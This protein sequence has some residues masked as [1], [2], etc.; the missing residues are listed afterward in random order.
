MLKNSRTYSHKVWICTALLLVGTVAQCGAQSKSASSKAVID[1]GERGTA[2]IVDNTDDVEATLRGFRMVTRQ[3]TGS[4]F[5]ISRQGYYITNAHVVADCPEGYPLRMWRWDGPNMARASRAVVLRKDEALDLALLKTDDLL[6]LQPLDLG[7]DTDIAPKTSVYAFG[8]P[9]GYRQ[10]PRRRPTRP[11]PVGPGVPIQPFFLQPEPEQTP[12]HVTTT[13]GRIT[14]LY[15]LR[16]VL[17]IIESSATVSHG[18]SGGP[19]LNNKGKVIGVVRAVHP[20]NGR[21]LALPVRDLK[22][23]LNRP[24][25]ALLLEPP[26]ISLSPLSFSADR[27]S[28]RRPFEVQVRRANGTSYPNNNAGLSVKVTLHLPGSESGRI[29]TKRSPKGAYVVQ[30]LPLLP[31]PGVR[32]FT[33]TARQGSHAT[34]YYRVKDQNLRVGEATI[35]LR[36][37]RRIIGGEQPSVLFAD[38][39]ER[40]ANV[41]GLDLLQLPDPPT[42]DG[43]RLDTAESISVTEI[44]PLPSAMVYRVEVMAGKRLLA[45]KSGQIALTGIPPRRPQSGIV[46]ACADE[47]PTNNTGGNGAASELSPGARQYIQNIADLFTAGAPG[48]FLI[49]TDHWTFGNPFQETLRAAGHTVT[50][51]LNPARLEGYDGV[52]VGGRTVPANQLLRYVKQGGRVY[53]AGGCHGN[54]GMFWNTFLN[55]FGL[56]MGADGRGDEWHITPEVKHTLFAGVTDLKVVGVSP[57]SKQ[58]GAWPNTRLIASPHGFHLWGVYS[59]DNDL[60]MPLSEAP[61]DTE[62]NEKAGD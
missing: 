38:G 17:K 10:P 15:G 53:V 2:L 5:C 56:T 60:L 31:Q 11:F 13:W 8:F 16:N 51:D 20:D 46:I 50:V 22:G 35:P 57:I 40:Q 26:V 39:T 55:A 33:L 18:S 28:P 27:R 43:V 19:L 61:P 62:H 23:F 24:D 25:I 29:G 52:F 58:P 14:T 21:N 42:P 41:T 30:A 12:P 6:N 49:C 3:I 7:S 36:T 4:A 9:G 44:P 47:W 59:T 37:I 1:R 32:R 34:A 54:D 48:N 45:E